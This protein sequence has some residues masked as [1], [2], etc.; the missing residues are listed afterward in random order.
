MG[1]ARAPPLSSVWPPSSTTTATAI[2]SG[3][4]TVIEIQDDPTPSE[5]LTVY[6]AH[7]RDRALG[8]AGRWLLDELRRIDQRGAVHAFLDGTAGT[9]LEIDEGNQ[10]ARG[11]PGIHV[12]PA[13]M[14]ATRLRDASGAAFL[15]AL[16]LGYEIGARIGMASPHSSGGRPL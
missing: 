8:V 10:Y 16:V 12:V 6:A 2:A 3:A 1:P 5:G 4:L 11:H 9:M 13:L 14:A 7:R 15:R